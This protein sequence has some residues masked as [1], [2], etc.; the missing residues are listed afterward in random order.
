MPDADLPQAIGAGRDEAIVNR[1]LDDPARGVAADLAGVEGDRPHQFLGR[2]VDGAV[3]ED[4][5]R[6]LAAQLQFHRHEVPAAGLGDHA[7]HLRRTGERHVLQPRVRRQGRAPPR[8]RI[9]SRR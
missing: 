4:H 9:R 6:A 1:P 3:G 8:C 2:L 5:R 7:A